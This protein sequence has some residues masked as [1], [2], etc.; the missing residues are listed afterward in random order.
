MQ[1]SVVTEVHA[2]PAQRRA[3][4]RC[5]SITPPDFSR[6]IAEAHEQ[7]PDATRVVPVWT[8][9]GS[10]ADMA[11]ELWTGLRARVVPWANGRPAR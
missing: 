1:T 5:Q 8:P 10:R 6:A 9:G 11:L 2:T 7:F 4:R 3:M